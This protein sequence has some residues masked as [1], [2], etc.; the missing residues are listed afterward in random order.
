MKSKRILKT[1]EGLFWTRGSG[2]MFQPATTGELLAEWFLFPA[3]AS[4]LGSC[5]SKE[6][7]LVAIC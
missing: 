4:E 7:S 3:S 1:Q 2:E 5:V 6:A